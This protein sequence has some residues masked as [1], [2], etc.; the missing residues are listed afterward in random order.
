MT[1]ALITGAGDLPALLAKRQAERPFVANLAG[2]APTGLDPDLTFRLEEL[3]GTLAILRESGVTDVCLVGKVSRPQVDMSALDPETRPLMPKLVAAMARGDDAALRAIV[4]IIEG[5]GLRIVGAHNL[6]A[7][8]LPPPGVLVGTLSEEAQRD[9]ARAAE[10]VVAMGQADIGQACIVSGGQALAVEALP[11]TDWMLRSLTVETSTS[12]ALSDPFGMAADW[13]SG[14]APK[15]LRD[16]TLPVGGLLFKAPKPG[17]ELRVDMPTIGP[18]TI[19]GAVQAGLDGVVVEAGGVLVAER[20]TCLRI[21]GAAG[22][23]LWV[24]PRE[25]A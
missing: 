13:L 22:L 6:A 2:H 1:L 4:D 8:L 10:I 18:A 17:Q 25:D 15:P 24:R 7:D 5:T 14:G 19:A 20:E 16:P 23:F 21:A 12:A 11:G 9:A 3:G